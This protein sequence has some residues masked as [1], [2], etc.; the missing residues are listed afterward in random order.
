VISETELCLKIEKSDAEFISALSRIL[1]LGKLTLEIISQKRITA[2]VP[3]LSENALLGG[4]GPGWL[5]L[6]ELTAAEPQLSPLPSGDAF[7]RELAKKYIWKML[8]LYTIA[9]GKE[10]I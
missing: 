7:D 9:K 3:G 4:Q 10:S 5:P 6:I 1:K 2:A 8:S